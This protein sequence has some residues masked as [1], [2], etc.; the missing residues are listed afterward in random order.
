MASATTRLK[1][2]LE[3]EIGECQPED[4]AARLDELDTLE[5]VLTVNRVEEEIGLLGALANE[6]RYKLVRLLVADSGELCVCELNAMVDASESAISHALATLN[7]A[8]LVTRQ[9]DGRWRKY[10]ATNA[11]V[12]LITVLDGVSGD[13]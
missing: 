10:Q 7:D 1:Q 4:V 3:D 9:K 8:G 13:E 12:A 6:T 2:H 5:A 11:A